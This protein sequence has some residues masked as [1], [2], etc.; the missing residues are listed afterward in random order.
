MYLPR[1]CL[2]SAQELGPHRITVNTYAPGII[3]TP[4]SE[5]ICILLPE[6]YSLIHK[7]SASRR[8]CA[9]QAARGGK[10]S[11]YGSDG[12]NHT[13]RIYGK[14]RGCREPS[15]IPGLGRGPLHYRT[16]CE[17][18]APA[19][20]GLILTHSFDRYLPAVECI[21]IEILYRH[22]EIKKLLSYTVDIRNTLGI[23]KSDNKPHEK[24]TS[25]R[26]RP[27]IAIFAA[28]GE[29]IQGQSGPPSGVQQTSSFP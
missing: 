14:T 3:D 23:P 28:A 11:P 7:C 12:G 9:L 16:E 5:S 1:F 6:K 8:C 2:L 29:R 26:L 13:S 17:F 27:G 4:M 25:R 19:S 18:Q 21:W 22:A 24:N 10:W 20:P 15:V